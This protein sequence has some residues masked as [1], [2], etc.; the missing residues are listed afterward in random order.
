MADRATKPGVF[1]SMWRVVTVAGLVAGVGMLFN[2]SEG[3][4]SALGKPTAPPGAEALA[5]GYE[6]KD[7][8][9]RAVVYILLGMG[10]TI[11][12]VVG[13]SFITVW[14]FNVHDAAMWSKL[15][16]QQT[17]TLIPPAPHLQVDPFSQLAQ[18][19][20]HEERLLHSYAWTSADHGVA[21]IPIDRAMDLMVGKSLDVA[22]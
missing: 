21:R 14:R 5:A 19:R 12:F 2:R 11:A 20:A 17:A 18:V 6:V 1:G 16:P 15:T 4:V 13:I 9:V 10:A 22:P 7:I 8:N 3:R